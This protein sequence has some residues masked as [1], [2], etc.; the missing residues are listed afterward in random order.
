MLA[1]ISAVIALI[2]LSGILACIEAALFSVSPLK[3]NELAQD[4]TRPSRVLA[5]I[6]NNLKKPI[7]ALVILTNFVNI[8]G[9]I[10]VGGMAG[11]HFGS[12]WV[13]LF[14]GILTFLI[15]IFAEIIPKNLGEIHALT[16]ARMTAIPV[17]LT[18]GLLTPAIWLIE[19]ITSPFLPEGKSGFSTNESEIR[20]M[21]KLG[22]KEGAIAR[23]EHELI[24]RAFE[25][26]DT[27]ASDIATPRTAMTYLR[28]S[29]TLGECREDIIASQHT[30]IIIVGETLDQVKGFTR[31]DFLL[32]SLL[33]GK[34]SELIESFSIPIL[35]FPADAP[36][37]VVLSKFQKSHQ[38]IGIVTDEFGGVSGIVTL[39]DVLEILAGEI[40]DENDRAVDLREYARSISPTRDEQSDD[41]AG[42]NNPVSNQ[43]E[44]GGNSGSGS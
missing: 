17:E 8:V 23:Q 27:K 3:V 1:I 32:Q 40:I 16:I 15:I 18:A 22:H 20:M 9:S 34:E 21:V 25:L 12:Q 41:K 29:R 2:V 14:S 39:E 26:D 36:A 4:G 33:Q 7:A 19:L 24:L 38:H 28:G 5:R 30:R 10:F 6:R 35:F 13:G 44:A 11:E 37:G 42:V 31:K 43:G